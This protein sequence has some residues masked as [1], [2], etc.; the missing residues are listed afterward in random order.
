MTT[1][2]TEVVTRRD[3]LTISGPVLREFTGKFHNIEF[4]VE[5][6]RAK[7]KLQFTEVEVHS[8]LAEY[9]HPT[10]EL[11]MN[12]TGPNNKPP[13][14]RSP[15]GRLLISCDEQG[16]EDIMELVGRTLRLRAHENLIEENKERN[17]E[18]G[19]FLSWSVIEVDG[20]NNRQAEDAA[21][22]DPTSE[23]DN[24]K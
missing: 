11:L 3:Q 13:S 17:Q 4:T 20:V 16:Y 10:A 23:P 22:S 24:P 21:D 1:Q 12:R 9:P 6:G 15:W 8:T 2:P 18:A 14:D 19:S 5:Q 7:S